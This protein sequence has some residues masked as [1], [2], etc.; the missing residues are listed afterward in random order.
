MQVTLVQWL[1]NP[2]GREVM[3]KS[4]VYVWYKWF[5]ESLHVKITNEDNAHQL[6]CYQGYCSL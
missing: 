6:L 3:K 5:K 4:S 2:Y 1:S